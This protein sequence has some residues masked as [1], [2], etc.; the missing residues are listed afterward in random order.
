MGITIGSL[1]YPF[2]KAF[3]V[4]RGDARSASTTFTV[5]ISP[6]VAQARKGVLVSVR[7]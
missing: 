1:H 4:Y 5:T 2:N 7:F 6:Q 3:D